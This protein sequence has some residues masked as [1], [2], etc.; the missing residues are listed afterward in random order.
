MKSSPV[1][2]GMLNAA[3]MVERYRFSQ[4]QADDLLI[5]WIIHS[6]LPFSVTSS[7]YFQSLMQYLNN[8]FQIPWSPNT[9]KSRILSRF[10][11][12]RTELAHVMQHAISQIHLSFDGW[13]SPHH[14]MAI[15]GIIAHFTAQS[16]RRVNPVIGLRLL[17]GSHTGANMAEVILEVLQHY[18]VAEHIGYCVADN[19]SNNDTLVKALGEDL[20]FSTHLYDASQRRLRCVGHVVNLVVRAFWFGD[21][22]RALLQ[23]MIVVTSDTMAQWR[24]M[25][26]W[27]KAHNITIYSLASPQRRQELKRLGGITVLQRD[28]ATRWNSGYNMIKSMLRNRDAIDVFCTRHSDL[29]DDRLDPEEWEQLSDAI[30]ILEP[31]QSATLRM[32]SDFAEIHNILVELDFL[33]STLTAV[34][35]KYQPNPHCHI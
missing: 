2:N 25:G 23:D 16:G 22:D 19:A 32:E 28:N 26:P 33:R 12:Q 27:G 8:K 20:I 34:L 3:N 10:E 5:L 13:T 7:P 9:I 21:V 29:E 6:N 18:G 14:T 4:K 11:S 1:I 35:R 17:E 15:L 30:A 31:F 24:L